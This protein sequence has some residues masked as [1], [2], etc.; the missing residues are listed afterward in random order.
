MAGKAVASAPSQ[1][2]LSGLDRLIAMEEIK[3]LELRFCRAH[4]THDWAALR[5]TIADD[6]ELYFA[7]TRGPGGPNVWTPIELT[8]AENFVAHVKRVLTGHSIHICTMPQFQ[9]VTADRA[10]ALWFIS[11]YGDIAGQAGLGFE[12][13]V[14]DYVRINGKW[15]IKK[16]DARIEAHVEF[17]K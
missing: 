16:A 4:D 9:S 15:L 13:L 14:K 12:R 5:S 8:G 6:F 2:E 11:G 7:Q 3:D 10:R 1:V 17:P